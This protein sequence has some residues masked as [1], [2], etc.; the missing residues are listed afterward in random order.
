VDD[1]FK[2]PAV[3]EPGKEDFNL[4]SNILSEWNV[5]TLDDVP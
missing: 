4:V 3:Y 2:T 1:S 5:I